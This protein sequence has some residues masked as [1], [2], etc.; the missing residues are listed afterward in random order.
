MHYW[1][2][3]NFVGLKAI[4]EQYALQ[5]DYALFAAYCLQK[6][7]GLKKQATQSAQDF[8]GVASQLALSRQREIAAQLA[9]LAFDNR[10]IHQ[11]LSF[12]LTTFIRQVLEKWANDEP[13]N[14]TAHKWLGYISADI[15]CFERALI[16]NPKDDL[17]IS[18]L[19][20]EQL[21]R[22]DYQSHHLSE[23]RFL[24][25]IAT[26]FASLQNAASL[27]DTLSSPEEKTAIQAQHDYYAALLACWQAYSQLE[28]EQDET[29]EP[30]PDWCAAKGKAFDFW[31]VVY[32][33]RP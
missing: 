24:G 33:D 13:L 18:Y 15:S 14:P 32:Y 5:P 21:N 10:H 4:G 8:V 9:A 11:L 20:K 3:S 26:A 6:E 2:R 23:S 28:T 27:I 22:V 31:S 12:H 25:D 16:L 17:C 7:Q 29:M 30:F 19:A 1:N